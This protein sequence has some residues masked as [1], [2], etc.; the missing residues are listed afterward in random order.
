MVH[1]VSHLFPAMTAETIPKPASGL[2]AHQLESFDE[3]LS[4][5]DRDHFIGT[6]R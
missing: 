6:S 4:L 1:F 2:H 3:R 5:W